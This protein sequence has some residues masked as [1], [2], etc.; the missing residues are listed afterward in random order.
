M[1]VG[2]SSSLTNPGDRVSSGRKGPSAP[3]VLGLV[4][5]L[6]VLLVL[7]FLGIHYGAVG[8]SWGSEWRALFDFRPSDVNEVIVRELRLPRVL[9][10]VE[11]GAALGLAGALMQGLTRNPLA[12]PGILGLNAGATLSIVLAT[13]AF[14]L[15]S[16]GQLVWFAFP[17]AAIAVVLVYA[18]AAHGPDGLS[19]TKLTL[20]GAVFSIVVYGFTGLFFYV[21]HRLRGISFLLSGRAIGDL[22]GHDMA[23]VQAVTPFIVVGVVA[24]VIFGRQLNGLQ[25]GDE[26]ASTLG[27]NVAWTRILV[28]AIVILLAG[29]SVAAVGSVAFV[30]L[31]IPHIVRGRFGT[32]Y[33][34]LLPYSALF[35]A[36]A[37]VGLDLI[38]RI[39]A[40]PYEIQIGL[41][42]ALV[43]VPIFL[44]YASRTRLESL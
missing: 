30:G 31:A 10:A 33:R 42:T 36:I 9:L 8:L 12:D 16:V 4:V 27:Q 29:A 3:R 34:W 22:G 21:S 11:V 14:G 19:P 2:R 44:Y 24:G 13:A 7:V 26:L 5:G 6:V 39:V 18:L 17:G 38:G 1:P 35:G 43:G 23:T 41:L 25:L 40:R 28:G 15:T 32:D 37:L 20:A